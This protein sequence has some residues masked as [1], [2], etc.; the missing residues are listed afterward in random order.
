MKDIVPALV[1]GQV[2]T[3]AR[4]VGLPSSP[5]HVLDLAMY[6]PAALVAGVLLLRNQAWG[7][8]IAPGLLVFLGLTG[9]PIVLTPFVA[10]GRGDPAGWAVLPPLA[11]VTIAS[12]VLAVR[13][14]GAVRTG[15]S[16]KTATT[17]DVQG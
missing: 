5:V 6:L 2:P 3:G 12:I 17:G 14:T 4:E 1:S 11:V 7:H 15:H 10:D 13:L 8:A 9:L 16:V